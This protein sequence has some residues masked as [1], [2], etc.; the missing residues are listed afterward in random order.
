MN[1]QS[2][3][4]SCPE[5]MVIVSFRSYVTLF[6]AD[7]FPPFVHRYHFL[8]IP[9]ANDVLS[10]CVSIVALWK[11][12]KDFN[13]GFVREIVAREREKLINEVRHTASS[14]NRG[15]FC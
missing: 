13:E 3:S 6:M 12:Q 1:W 2:S 8:N 4:V 9:E 15:L 5:K 14:Y 10:N 11:S 7:R